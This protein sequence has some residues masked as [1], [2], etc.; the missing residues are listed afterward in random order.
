[1]AKCIACCCCHEI[2]PVHAITMEPSPLFKLVQAIRP[3]REKGT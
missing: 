3:K 2:C 1:L